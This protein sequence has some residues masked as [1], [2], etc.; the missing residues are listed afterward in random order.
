MRVSVRYMA[1]LRTAAGV[2]V[3][4]VEIDGRLHGLGPWRPGLAAR[5]GDGLR[6][7]LLGDD[8]R[9]GPAILVIIGDAQIVTNELLSLKDGDV[10]TLLSP[11]AG[12]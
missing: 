3:E 2:A 11:V 6:R 7:L 8:G 10:I 5:H 12:G 9:I 1:Q 4:A